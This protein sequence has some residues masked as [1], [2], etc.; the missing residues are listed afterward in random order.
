VPHHAVCPCASRSVASTLRSP[1]LPRV[2]DCGRGVCEARGVEV[3]SGGRAR[4]RARLVHRQRARSRRCASRLWWHRDGGARPRHLLR[5][6]EVT[7]RC[8]RPRRSAAGRGT[9]AW[10]L[11]APASAAAPEEERGVPRGSGAVERRTVWSG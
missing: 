5:R 9:C 2:R 1:R 4:G 6:G 11:F 3:T 8:P 10:R 7:R